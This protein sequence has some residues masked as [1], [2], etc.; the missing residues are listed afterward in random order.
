M[1][2]NSEKKFI[3]ESNMWKVMWTLSWPAVIAM[4]LYGLNTVFDAIFVG[5]FVGETALAGVTIA[6][7]Y[8]QLTLAVG[9]LIGVGAGSALSIAIGANDQSTQRKL[10]GNVNYLTIVLSL[11]YMV[12]A[13]TFAEPL[14]RIMGGTG[15]ALVEGVVYFRV[16]VI[17]TVFWVYGLSSNMIIRAEGRMKTA[18]ILMGIGLVANIIANYILIVLL[19]MGVAGAAWGTNF[20]ML[21]YTVAGLIY[22]KSGKATFRSKVLTI[23]RD[24]A[25]INA[26]FRMGVPSFIMSVMGLIQAFVIFNALKNYGNVSDI[27]FYGA[28]NRIYLFTLT[29]IFGLMRALQPVVGINYGAYKIER[30]IRSFKI[31]GV[32]ATALMLPIWLISMFAPGLILGTMLPTRLFTPADLANY[33]VYMSALILLPTVFMMMTFLPSIDRG[34]P[35]AIIG[36]IRQLVF[37]VPVMLI[38]PRLFGVKFVYIGSTAI[39]IIIVIIVLVI[40]KMEFKRLR[41]M[42]KED[43]R[44]VG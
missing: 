13:Y 9:S 19:G 25:I 11:I 28:A 35:A 44:E 31:F 4:V 40:V 15:D 5:N 38:L 1:A 29:P 22:F 43:L 36:L 20:G 23:A 18:A 14:I 17:G 3:L 16:T 41:G 24:K 34:K 12:I 33:R 6:Y 27:A 32:V 21:V 37:F 39:D 26:I 7:P 2:N 42:D 10:L 8:S 30:A